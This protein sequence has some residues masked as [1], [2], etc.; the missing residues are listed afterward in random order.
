MAISGSSE[1]RPIRIDINLPLTYSYYGEIKQTDEK[2]GMT[3]D[4]STGGLFF[5]TESE[6]NMHPSGLKPKT[7]VKTFDENRIRQ[8]CRLRWCWVALPSDYLPDR[9]FSNQRFDLYQH[10]DLAD[11]YF[12][13]R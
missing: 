6:P 2:K 13:T 4:I 5:E 3:I 9:R 1:Q 8:D 12:E 11:R 10:W 7:V